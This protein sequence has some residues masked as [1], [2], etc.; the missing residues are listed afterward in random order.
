MRVTRCLVSYGEN[1]VKNR[2][3]RC[4]RGL[5]LWNTVTAE[6]QV[7]K[8]R[9]SCGAGKQGEGNAIPVHLY[10][11]TE[12]M[13]SRERQYFFLNTP[14]GF[15]YGKLQDLVLFRPVFSFC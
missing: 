8:R 2:V 14:W 1:W 6:G 11:D 5:E 13:A 4:E 7:Q 12:L 3:R 10:R 15:L 9:D